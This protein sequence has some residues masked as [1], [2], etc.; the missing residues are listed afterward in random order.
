[1]GKTVQETQKMTPKITRKTTMV[2]IESALLEIIRFAACQD[3]RTIRETMEKVLRSAFPG[4][5][6][7]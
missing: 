2:R 7:K 3:R 4:G 6:G 1:M 5:R